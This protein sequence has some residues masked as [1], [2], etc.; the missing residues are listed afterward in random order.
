MRMCVCDT[1][2]QSPLSEVSPHDYCV[3]RQRIS[4]SYALLQEISLLL[5]CFTETQLCVFPSLS[6]SPSFQS[7]LLW[8]RSSSLGFWCTLRW[9]FTKN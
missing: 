1:V 3:N 5:D 4:L 7:H 9:I 8:F 6:L 2:E